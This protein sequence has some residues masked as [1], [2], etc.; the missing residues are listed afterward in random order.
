MGFEKR[1]SARWRLNYPGRIDAGDGSPQ[2][3]C[4]IADISDAGAKLVIEAHRATLK[5][6]T[7]W[8]S[9]SKTRCRRCHVVWRTYS[10]IGV[11][12]LPEE[13]RRLATSQRRRSKE[14]PAEPAEASLCC[15]RLRHHP[16][17][18]TS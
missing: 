18:K 12:F 6:F 1:Q 5:Q 17:R 11:E 2:R 7:L 3:D 15:P 16:E 8:M 13:A 9:G 10:E 14:A 4:L